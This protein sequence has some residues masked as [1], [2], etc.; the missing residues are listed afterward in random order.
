MFD[1]GK[2]VQRLKFCPHARCGRD[3]YNVP[4]LKYIANNCTN[5]KNIE[6]YCLH[7]TFEPAN[8]AM[9]LRVMPELVSFKT[10]ASWQPALDTTLIPIAEGSCP[11]LTSLEIP[12]NGDTERCDWILRRIGEH[13]PR[14]NRLKT[15]WE[16]R[17]SKM[18]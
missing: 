2:M 12:G 7:G 10:E 15:R 18:A 9:F 8:I 3:K 6:F 16:I 4:E 17:G 1:Y 5:V 13:C 11:K 14:I